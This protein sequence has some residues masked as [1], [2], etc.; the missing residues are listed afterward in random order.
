MT[1]DTESSHYWYM[2][3]LTGAT[4]VSSLIGINTDWDS[5]PCLP[6]LANTYTYQCLSIGIQTDRHWCPQMLKGLTTERSWHW[7]ISRNFLRLRDVDAYWDQK[8]SMPITRYWYWY[9]QIR[10]EIDRHWCLLISKGFT[11]SWSWCLLV[12]KLVLRRIGIVTYWDQKVPMP[13][14]LYLS[15]C[16]YLCLEIGVWVYRHWHLMIYKGLAIDKS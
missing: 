11:I 15:I 7:V 6:L 1:H 13:S 14:D 10:L 2:L 9:L 3:V 12:S 8:V 5:Y 16:W 4:S